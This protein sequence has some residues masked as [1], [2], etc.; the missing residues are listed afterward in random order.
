MAVYQHYTAPTIP[1]TSGAGF[2]NVF[3]RPEYQETA[4]SNYFANYDPGYPY[5]S[6]TK[7]KNIGANG[8]LYNRNGRAYPDVAANGAWTHRTYPPSSSPSHPPPL[9][10]PST[11]TVYASGTL[12]REGGTSMAAPLVASIINLLNEER[13][14]AGKAT[15]GFVNPTFYGNPQAFHDITIGANQGCGLTFAFNCT[16]GWDPVT[17]LGTPNYNVLKQ[18]F[19]QLP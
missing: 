8:G 12:I 2:S 1:Y 11:H 5:Y 19:M 14:A 3:A 7:G 16:P 15:V 13:L 9:T 18:V 6:T 17:G 10:N 4:V